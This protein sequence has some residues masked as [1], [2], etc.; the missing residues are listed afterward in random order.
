MSSHDHAA[1]PGTVV[2]RSRRPSLDRLI[3][4]GETHVGR[5]VFARRAIKAGIVLGAKMAF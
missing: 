2:S 1:T 3:R 5:G 4:V